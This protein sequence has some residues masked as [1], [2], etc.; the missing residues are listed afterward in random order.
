M[1][2][3]ALMYKISLRFGSNS[4]G[5]VSLCIIFYICDNV[6]IALNQL[7][8]M[9][10]DQNAMF[11]HI[12]RSIFGPFFQCCWTLL[13]GQYFFFNILPGPISP[14]AHARILNCLSP[15]S[16][17]HHLTSCA[18][19][20]SNGLESQIIPGGRVTQDDLIRLGKF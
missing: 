11:C 14:L 8:M 5:N 20:S 7:F 16:C 9:V 15:Q 4:F 6:A 18:C 3:Q 19:D 13:H 17:F 1:T 12:W 10:A 2:R